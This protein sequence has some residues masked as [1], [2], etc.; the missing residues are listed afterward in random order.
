ML[1]FP[2]QAGVGVRCFGT[3]SVSNLAAAPQAGCCT[4]H[5]GSGFFIWKVATVAAIPQFAKRINGPRKRSVLG[6]GASSGGWFPPFPCPKGTGASRG[7]QEPVPH[8]GGTP[9]VH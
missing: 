1:A 8:L 2:Q 9:P 6:E 7:Q 4:Y 5:C 3:H